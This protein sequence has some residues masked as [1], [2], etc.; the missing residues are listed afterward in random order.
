MLFFDLPSIKRCVECRGCEQECPAFKAVKGYDPTRL[1]REILAG[2]AMEWFGYEMVWQCL[3][4]H[5]C[6]EMCPQNYSWEKVMTIFKA[7]AM[8]RGLVP[9]IVVRGIAT[10]LKTGKLGEPK[11]AVR[12]A[13]G[14]PDAAADGREDFLRL[15]EALGVWDRIHG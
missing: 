12:K 10:F 4:C 11:T 7:E 15:V 14:L 1:N 5:T 2:R 8:R 9:K 3:E 6:T 13:L